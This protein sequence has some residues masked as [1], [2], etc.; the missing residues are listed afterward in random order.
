MRGVFAIVLLA[1]II[2][3]GCS[4]QQRSGMMGGAGL[5]S[6]GGMPGAGNGM[7]G[8]MMGGRDFE[9]INRDTTGLEAAA[10]QGVYEL[11][12]GSVFALEAGPVAK[13]IDG[14][15]IRAFAYN[16][17]IPG[18][19]IRVRQGSTVFVNFTNSLD[20]NTTVHWHGLRLQ[21]RYDGVPD[22][23]QRAVMPGESFLYRLEFPD[24]GAYWY[25]P[26]VREDLQ[27]ELGLYGFILVEPNESGYY[28]AVDREEVLALDD[29]LLSGGDVYPFDSNETN[30]ALM[31]RFG[32]VML[33]NGRTDYS[34]EVENGERVR[35][36]ILDA[37]NVRTFNLSIDGMRMKVVGGDGGKAEREYLADSVIISP[38]E[39]LIVEVEFDKPSTYAIKNRNPLGEQTLGRVVVKE[40]GGDGEGEGGFYALKNNSDIISEIGA[41]EEYFDNPADFDYVLTVDIE[42]MGMESGG[43]GDMMAH[44][45]EG[46]EW[47]DTMFAMNSF[48]TSNRTTWVIKDRMSGKKNMDAAAAIPKGKVV[49]IRIENDGNS[50]HPMQHALHLHGAQ[51]LVLS[52]DG[53]KNGNLVW[54]DTVNI[55][56]GKTAELLTYFPNEGEWMM[57]CH[58]AEH[59][60]SGMMTSFEVD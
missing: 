53:Q 42:G 54:K 7:A 25:H 15:M 45:E 57:H 40:S 3:A 6:G 43:M 50:A 2:S 56:S 11:E 1:T 28:N 35:F 17:Q 8:G 31:G 47:E 18:P 12:N 44:I 23:T 22:V 60:G 49:K 10:G 33:V 36:F 32:N 4:A 46:I 26:H 48:S 16:G 37:A 41:Y 59:L 14:K 38:S 9:P 20:S 58:I 19:V 30:F 5:A 55:P 51:F 39:R 13:E 21:N 27:Q 34:L 24:E 52:M 29:I